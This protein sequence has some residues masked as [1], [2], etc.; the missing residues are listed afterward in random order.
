MEYRKEAKTRGVETE[1]RRRKRTE[2]RGAVWKE[3]GLEARKKAKLTGPRNTKKWSK[4]WHIC[5]R[6]I[7]PAE[8]DRPE[9]ENYREARIH[10]NKRS[11]MTARLHSERI[12]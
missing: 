10:R 3:S 5:L 11:E 7:I 2:R 9:M 1:I 8:V 12:Q 4:A 6:R